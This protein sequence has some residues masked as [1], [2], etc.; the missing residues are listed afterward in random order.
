[1]VDGA[2]RQMDRRKILCLVG[3]VAFSVPFVGAAADTVP[4]S[5][6]VTRPVAALNAGLLAEM[7][8]GRAVPFATRYAQLEPLIDRVFDLPAILQSAIGPP[9]WQALTPEEQTQLLDAFRRYTVST[10]VAN[11]DKFGGES[12]VILPDRRNIAEVTVVPTQIVPATG[13]PARIDY[14]LHPVAGD[15]SSEWKIVDVFLDGSISQVAVQR[16]EFRGALRDGGVKQLIAMFDR[17]ATTL[18]IG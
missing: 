18:S 2:G 11:F 8:T 13:K 4:E 14:V 6:L 10:Y 9:H 3:A 1:M 17:K 15:A 7:K 12:F 16:S 5:D